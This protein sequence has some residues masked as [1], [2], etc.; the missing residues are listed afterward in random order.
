VSSVRGYWLF[1]RPTLEDLRQDLRVVTGKCRP[2]WD[3]TTPELKAA[4][5]QGRKEFFYPYGKTYVQS[6]GEQDEELHHRL[7]R[8]RRGRETRRLRRQRRGGSTLPGFII[9]SG[10]SAALIWRIV[11]SSAPPRHSGIR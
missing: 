8:V 1:G 9:P 11:S 4:W 10:S 6:L 5:Q 3:I 7:W 2:D